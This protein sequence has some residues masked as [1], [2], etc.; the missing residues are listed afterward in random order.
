MLI[1]LHIDMTS[2]PFDFDPL[3]LDFSA[4]T[5]QC[6]QP[7]PT[8]S[9]FNPFPTETSWSIQP[10]GQQ[11]YTALR[12]Y[13]SDEFRKW[14]I[15]CAAATTA[16][17]EDIQYPPSES[18]FKDDPQEAVRRAE[19]LADDLEKKVSDHIDTAYSRW[20]ALAQD[21][22]QDTWILE[23]ARS[24][25]KKQAQIE[26]M[27]QEQHALRQENSNLR[28][29][30]DQLN[31]LQ[32][33][34]EYKLMV[35]ATLPVD[36]KFLEYWQEQAV[37]HGRR[38]VGMNL[39]D[40]RSEI[41]TVVGSAIDRW[42]RVV[43]SHRPSGSGVLGK[44]TL[45]QSGLNGEDHAES[46][47]PSRT[48]S[49]RTSSQNKAQALSNADNRPERSTTRTGMSGRAS[50]LSLRSSIQPTSNSD[51]GDVLAKG[52]GVGKAVQP[53]G[54][55]E[56]PIFTLRASAS[57]AP[58]TTGSTPV[59]QGTKVHAT[60]APDKDADAEQDDDMSDHDGNT[61]QDDGMSDKDAD[62]EMEDDDALAYSHVN[63]GAAMPQ[64]GPAV[65]NNQS[66]GAALASSAQAQASTPQSGGEA[67]AVVANVSI[68]GGN[69][70]A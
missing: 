6:L 34:R 36:E 64:T 25:G 20:E 39:D 11:Q 38:S 27:Q 13:F 22:K 68:R 24:I 43:V 35:P 32:Q 67:G 70:R 47:S 30:I 54:G 37:V 60:L 44:R 66:S 4:L 56:E 12:A 65:P 45:D 59:I 33:P 9:S 69:T 21:R 55:A 15:K 29:Q 52:Q 18:A 63:Q 19:K 62:A 28:S 10:P 26:S 57:R 23:L 48:A 58:P 46:R 14:R 51:A 3:S 1:R 2:M 17:Q 50:E 8:L 40:R 49:H 16:L 5:L 7:P 61:D 53:N 42:K 41:G 31:K